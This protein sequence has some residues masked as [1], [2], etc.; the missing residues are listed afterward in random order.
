MREYRKWILK[1]P[2]LTP[3]RRKQ[4]VK[5][6]YYRRCSSTENKSNNF[7]HFSK[8][9]LKEFALSENRHQIRSPRKIHRT[10]KAL[11]RISAQGLISNKIKSYNEKAQVV[12]SLLM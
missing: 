3:S 6:Y 7:K 10:D 5:Y 1:H 11:S 4:Q 8:K 9:M 2:K 12:E